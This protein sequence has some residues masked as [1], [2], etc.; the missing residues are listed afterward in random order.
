MSA[1]SFWFTGFPPGCRVNHT[2]FAHAITAQGRKMAYS[3]RV[4]QKIFDKNGG[5]KEKSKNMCRN[6]LRNRQNLPI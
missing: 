1:H 2:L 6:Y 5:R 4:I 3:G